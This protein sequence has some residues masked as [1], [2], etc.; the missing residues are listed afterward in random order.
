[1]SMIQERGTLTSTTRAYEFLL[2]KRLIFIITTISLIA[3]LVCSVGIALSIGQVSVPFSDSLR[4]VVYQMSGIS[5]GSL[6]EQSL[7]IHTDIV[8]SIRFPRVLLAMLIGAG[9]A[10]CG[11]VMQAS[12]QNPL[13]DPYILGISSGA[14]L[15]ATFSIMIGFGTA[16]IIGSMGT[17]FWAFLGALGAATLVLVVANLSGKMS[18]IK[19]VLAGTVIHALCSAFSSFIV[20]F[21]KDAEGIRSVTF[22]TMGSLASAKWDKLM[23]LAI[24]IVFAAVFFLFQ[25]RIM[26]TMLTGEET[27]VTLGINLNAYRR[28]YMVICSIL[29]GFM[30]AECGIIGFVGLIIPHIVRSMVGSD[31]RRL[32]PVSIL[33]GAMFMIWTDVLSRSIIPNSELPIGIVTALLGAPMF[34]YMVMKKNYGF[35]GK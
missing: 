32:L 23:L 34:M 28:F 24:V 27:A 12:V 16:G 3:A 6:N 18:S 29:T 2:K 10:L 9:L 26:N 7:A 11:T 17:A 21:A 30:V 14:S 8:W 13:A 35:G 25:A 20:F 4:I 22:W 19:L 5:S 33:L 15:G 1:M 31:H